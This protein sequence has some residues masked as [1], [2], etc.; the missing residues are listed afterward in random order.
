MMVSWKKKLK[1]ENSMH[2]ILWSLRDDKISQ[3]TK[4]TASRFLEKVK[5]KWRIGKEVKLA[6]F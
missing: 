3:S 2:S 5:V 4:K 6:T 1:L